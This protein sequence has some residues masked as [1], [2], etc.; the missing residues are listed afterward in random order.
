LIERAYDTDTKFDPGHKKTQWQRFHFHVDELN[1]N[2][3]PNIQ[4]KVLYRLSSLFIFLEVVLTTVKLAAMAKATITLQKLFTA[5]KP[6]MYVSPTSSPTHINEIKCYW[7]AQDGNGDLVWSDANLT[8]NGVSQALKANDFWRVLT[9]DHGIPLPQSYY[10][11]PLLRCLTTAH[12]TFA[13]LSHTSES[14]FLPTIKEM[15]REAMGVHTCD[16]RSSKSRIQKLF[17]QWPIEEGFKENDPLWVPDLRETDAAMAVR[18]RSAMDDI[19]NNDGKT[20]ISIS[21]HSG[22]I[23]SLLKCKLKP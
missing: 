6:G 13:G 22:M 16:R 5:P 8:S 20:H 9:T 1:R 11:S 4:F 12:Y 15:L 2:S 21:S 3:A 10:S 17:P 7:S 19:F 14:P 23:A 18:A